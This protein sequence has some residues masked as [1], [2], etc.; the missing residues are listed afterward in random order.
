VS[1]TLDTRFA[2]RGT[3][4]L[5]F[6]QPKNLRGFGTPATVYVNARPGSIAPGPEDDAIYT[7]DAELKPAY[8]ESSGTPPYIGSRYPAA[9][10]D[11]EGHFDHIRPPARAFSSTTAY[12][13]V[14]CVLEIW[15]GYLGRQVTWHFANGKRRLELIPRSETANAW[16]GD[17][18]VELGFVKGN[19]ARPFC[20]NFDVVAHEVG[21]L[22]SWA[23]IGKP[24]RRSMAYRANDEASAD[25]VA[26]VTSLHFDKVV[27]HL[28]TRTAGN[29][30]SV[31]VLSRIGELSRTT[32]ARKAFNSVR[33]STVGP[34]ADKYR[35]SLPFTGGAFEVLVG[36]YEQELVDHRAISEDVRQRSLAARRRDLAAVQLA[37]RRSFR[38]RRQKF[39]TALFDAR[40]YFGRLLTSAWEKTSMHARSHATVAVHMMAADRELSGGRYAGLIRRCFEQRDILLTEAG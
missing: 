27:S 30:L 19:W 36:I 25:L 7:V 6:P 28:L 24:R 14:R 12:A 39:E 3:R 33:M 11:G 8:R 13:S 22:L 29:L 17:G 16:S 2:E 21:H 26:I 31:N 34:G 5:V 38:A 1:R 32:Q 10:P 15:E 40:D 20:E 35:R 37:F 18:Y 23:V 4:F 9:V